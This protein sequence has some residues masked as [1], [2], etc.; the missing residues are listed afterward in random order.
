MR[1]ILI[2]FICLITSLSS[3]S[4]FAE[5]KAIKLNNAA[6]FNRSPSIFNKDDF[7]TSITKKNELASKKITETLNTPS[8]RTPSEQ[9]NLN[10]SQP[11]FIPLSND[12]P[13]PANSLT[14]ESDSSKDNKSNNSNTPGVLLNSESNN[15]SSSS[16]WIIT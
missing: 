13:Y 3:T 11:K 8:Q 5:K 1:L 12:K 10:K 14:K 2:F 16:P 6:E 7:S 4:A 15:N 9:D